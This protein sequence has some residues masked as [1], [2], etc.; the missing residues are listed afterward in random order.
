MKRTAFVLVF[1]LLTIF[2]C[3]T[4]FSSQDELVSVMVRYSD[5][6][7]R[8]TENDEN[9]VS[10]MN[11]PKASV[12]NLK[13]QSNVDRVESNYKVKKSTVDSDWY[14]DFDNIR[15]VYTDLNAYGEN[16]KIAILDTGITFTTGYNVAGGINILDNT[17]N[18]NDDNGHGSVMANIIASIAPQSDI[19]S[20]KVLDESGTG[21]Y[22]D[23]IEGI[24]WSIEN[25][26]DIICMSFGAFE[27]SFFLEEA[28]DKAFN[29]NIVMIAASGN[30]AS[31]RMHYPAAYNQVI[32]VGACDEN[33]N[34]LNFTNGKDKVDLYAPGSNV[35]SRN[36]RDLKIKSKG[37][38]VSAA[39]VV[40]VASLMKSLKQNYNNNDLYNVIS[41]NIRINERGVML[42]LTITIRGMKHTALHTILT[43]FI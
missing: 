17:E 14:L 11:I 25:D 13:N 12:V 24:E 8:S 20:V 31:E 32:S 27:Y 43:E 1:I 29:N 28:I 41:H 22:S 9:N 33:E 38:S 15:E 39:Q 26:I 7:Q 23:V 21:Y 5:S 2:M 30:D 40:G 10:V 16:V 4:S 18:F 19:Y 42:I 3:Q 34:I 35:S 6:M 37:T 36:H